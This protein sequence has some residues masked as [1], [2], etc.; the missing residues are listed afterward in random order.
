M[1]DRLS[2]S[3]GRGQLNAAQLVAAYAGF[4][5]TAPTSLELWDLTSASLTGMHADDLS[6]VARSL[7]QLAMDR[8]PPGRSA[9]VVG[10]QEPGYAT[11]RTLSGFLCRQ[12]YPVEVEVF[13]DTKEERAW[14]LGAEAQPAGCHVAGK[15]N[16]RTR[17][18]E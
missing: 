14:L 6:A 17:D 1:G 13:R 15:A 18:G 2:V 12:Q 9:L 11:A 16:G 10:P 4:L 7:V 8:R 3:L 5:G